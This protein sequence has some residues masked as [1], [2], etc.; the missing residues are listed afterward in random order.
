MRLTLQIVS[1]FSAVNLFKN[2][3]HV[4]KNHRYNISVVIV[5]ILRFLFAFITKQ[6]ID[7]LQARSYPE[8]QLKEKYVRSDIT[9]AHIFYSHFINAFRADG[10]A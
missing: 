3:H 7:D 4:N 2:I 6:R 8:K 10:S 9:A 5:I 1:N